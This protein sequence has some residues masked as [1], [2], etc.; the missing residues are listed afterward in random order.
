M[1]VQRRVPFILVALL[2]LTFAFGGTALPIPLSVEYFFQGG[3][4]AAAALT[5]PAIIRP[6]R[7]GWRLL[8]G[9]ACVV[10][11]MLLTGMYLIE[12]FF[13]ERIGL[14]GVLQTVT[15]AVLVAWFWGQSVVHQDR[16]HRLTSRSPG[17]PHYGENLTPHHSSQRQ[18]RSSP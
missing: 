15:L 8:S 6:E 18:P 16:P 4:A 11:F 13:P 17:V 9:V 5:V 12:G 14:F 10:W 3:A 7:A 2:L 1:G